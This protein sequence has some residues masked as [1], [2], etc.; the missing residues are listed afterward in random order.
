MPLSLPIFR[1]EDQKLSLLQTQWASVISPLLKSPLATPVILPSIRLATGA[2]V[3]SHRL[4]HKLQ[5]WVIVRMRSAAV[6]VYDTQD[7]N[8]TPQLTLQLTSSGAATVDILV[9]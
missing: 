4:G 9:F 3:I 6:T 7:T 1:T 5:G 2:N 8:R